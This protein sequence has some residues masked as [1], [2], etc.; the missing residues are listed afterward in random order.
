VEL[1]R[2]RQFRDGHHC[3]QANF[4]LTKRYADPGA[5]RLD[6]KRTLPECARMNLAA[7]TLP[8]LRNLSSLEQPGGTSGP[9]DP[10]RP[11]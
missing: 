6:P 4:A 1:Q 2:T 11:G 8:S 9:A 7:N 5:A 10:D 3:R